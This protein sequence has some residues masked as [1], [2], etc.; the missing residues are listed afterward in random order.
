MNRKKKWKRILLQ[1]VKIS[2]GS[3]AAI[4]TAQHLG[5]QNAASA[6]SIA[7]LTI[8]T[9]KWETVKLSVYRL[10]T[11]G[12]T[13]A[14]AKIT[15]G[16]MTSGWVAYGAFIFLI[17]VLS[18]AMGWQ[19]AVSVNAVIGT[20]FLMAEDFSLSFVW[21]E[22][23]LV[24]IGIAAAVLLNLFYDYRNQKNGLIESMRDTEQ[25]LQMIL[26]GL[27]AYLSNKEMQRNIWKDIC[28]LE[29][30]LQEYIK[31]ACEYQDNT[32]HSHPGYYIDYFEMRMKQLGILHNLH[33]EIKKIRQ[34]PRQAEIIAEYIL[35]MA[36]YVIEV[37]LPEAQ[38]ERLE[39]IF[40]DMKNGPLPA[41]REEF[42]G[43]A[44]LYHI[45]MDLEEF[46]LF[47]KRFVENMD[48]DRLKRYWNGG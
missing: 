45:L 17:I 23:L 21:N 27:A 2:V 1:A 31:D 7:L 8:V 11:F 19:A 20:H 15:I 42:E 3:S 47:K 33:Y 44:V 4:F 46:L 41:S 26:G 40:G 38:I 12:I 34:M 43:R 30:D 10:I 29:E 35:Y 16:G 9:T 39:E 24:F 32:F 48:E 36:D 18:H 22:F 13:V 14:L 28:V 25:R 37:N 6:G 5:L